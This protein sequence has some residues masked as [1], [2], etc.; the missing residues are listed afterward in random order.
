MQTQALSGDCQSGATLSSLHAQAP[1]FPPGQVRVAA[2]MRSDGG[3]GQAGTRAKLVGLAI[4]GWG[5]WAQE[6][7]PRPPP[8][9]CTLHTQAF[10]GQDPTPLLLSRRA[11]G[12]R[13]STQQRTTARWG[14]RSDLTCGFILGKPTDVFVYHSDAVVSASTS[15][16][17]SHRRHIAES[18]AP[19]TEAQLVPDSRSC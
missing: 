5:F 16:R 2:A 18:M 12:L 19:H 14:S 9:A 10:E 6:R 17:S 11:V 7:H 1:V 8:E 4:R 15:K 13:T 3:R